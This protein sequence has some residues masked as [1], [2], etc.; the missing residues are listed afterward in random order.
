MTSFT[1]NRG[2]NPVTIKHKCIR[3]NTHTYTHTYIHTYTYTHTYIHT[4]IHTY[5]HTHIRTYIHTHTD[6]HTYTTYTYIPKHIHAYVHTYIHTYI[7]PSGWIFQK[8][9]PEMVQK[10]LILSQ[11]RLI[12]NYRNFGLFAPK[13][14]RFPSKD[15]KS[16]DLPFTSNFSLLTKRA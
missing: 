10:G 16:K 15:S 9:L 12:S 13:S 1:H 6:T 7:H 8:V 2:T 5:I 11:K 14:M 3:T 4:H